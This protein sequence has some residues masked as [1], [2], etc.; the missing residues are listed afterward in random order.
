MAVHEKPVFMASG[1][2]G[3]RHSPTALAILLHRIP[4]L[5]AA[6]APA[7]I[8]WEGRPD[9]RVLS[10]YLN[11]EQA[12]ETN[13]RRGFEVSLANLLRSV[14]EQLADERE[15]VH[16]VADAEGVRGFAA[17]YKAGGKSLAVMDEFER[18]GVILTDRAQ[19]RPFTVF[20]GEIEEPLESLAADE[21][22][23]W[24]RSWP[25]GSRIAPLMGGLRQRGGT[26][27]RAGEGH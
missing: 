8:R 13:R 22:K 3:K 6:E 10:V 1:L 17:D 11:V 21:K 24:W 12:R 9:G 27:H 19:S 26:I 18:Y 25:N 4:V 5:P 20:M 14:E 23:H 2:Q 16:F 7:L 15:R